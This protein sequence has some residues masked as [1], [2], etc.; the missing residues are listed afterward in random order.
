[1]PFIPIKNVSMTEAIELAKEVAKEAS[2]KYNLPVF[3][4]VK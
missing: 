1:V 2:E 3:L 4:Y